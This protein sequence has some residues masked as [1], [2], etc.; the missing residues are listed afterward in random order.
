MSDAVHLCA[1]LCLELWWICVYVNSPLIEQDQATH[2][3][4]YFLP[5]N[6]PKKSLTTQRLYCIILKRI[7]PGLPLH[8]LKGGMDAAQLSENPLT[9]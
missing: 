1:E 2:S 5:Q 9:N 8:A 3:E 6:G 4:L 7:V